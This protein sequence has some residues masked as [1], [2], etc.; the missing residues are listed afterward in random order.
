MK[1][2]GSEQII[3]AANLFI[4]LFSRS[5]NSLPI[6]RLLVQMG[7]QAVQIDSSFIPAGVH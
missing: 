2:P 1:A 6:N 3:T 5:N 7:P 4:Y